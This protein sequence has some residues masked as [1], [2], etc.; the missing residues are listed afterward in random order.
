MEDNNPQNA[1]VPT[2]ASHASYPVK[3]KCP[4]CH[5][6]GVTRIQ[7]GLGAASWVW[8]VLLSPFALSGL[9]CLCIDSC[10]DKV[11]YC[12]RCGNVVGKK[13]AKVC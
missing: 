11:H 7:T 3:I 4:K 13:F 2:D 12:T 10:R 8:C 5:K 9:A 1:K 6:V